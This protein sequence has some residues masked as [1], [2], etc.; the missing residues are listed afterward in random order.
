MALRVH[1]I[2]L[3][4]TPEQA[5]YFRKCAADARA[6]W[7]W[8]LRRYHEIKAEMDNE[9]NN[10]PNLAALRTQLARLVQES[11][12]SMRTLHSLD[13][14]RQQELIRFESLVRSTTRLEAEILALLC[15]NRGASDGVK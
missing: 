9:S 1:K 13:K 6:V 14:R 12:A 2:K 5:L 8:A 11:A 4:P 10:P 15:A 3:N 7:N